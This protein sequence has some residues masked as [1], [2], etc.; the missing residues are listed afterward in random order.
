MFIFLGLHAT[1]YGAAEMRPVKGT[2]VDPLGEPIIGA[3]VRVKGGTVGAQTDLNGGFQ[4]TVSANVTLI[5]SYM[6]YAT[7]EIA[8]TFDAPMKIVL[9]ESSQ[10]LEDVVITAFGTS[11]KKETLTG[12]IQTI[13]PND[14]IA[15]T[16][17]LSNAFAGRLAGVIAFQRSGEPGNSGS[18][19]Y[20]RGISTLSGM[21]SPLIILDGLEVSKEDLNSV[22]PEII[23][24]FS[25]LKDATASAM[26]GTRGANG[27]MIVKTKSG[28]NLERPIIGVRVETNISMPTGIPKF[29]DGATYMELNNEAVT[30][31]NS[32]TGLFS[33]DQILNTRNG[34]D[35]YLYPNVDWYGEVFKDY[36]INQ[37]AN[38]NIRGG[39]KKIVYFMNMTF[40]HETSMLRDRAKEFFSYSN[41]IDLLKYAFQNNI[42]FHL[43]ET[44][45][46]SLHLN[47]QL[48]DKH[49]PNANTENIYN[50]IMIS[51]PVDFPVYYPADE[52]NPWVY[53]G[54]FAGGN[55][56]GAV[57]TVAAMTYGYRD[58]FESTVLANLDFDQ[59]LNF[60]TEGLSFKAKV[61]FKTWNKSEIYRGSSPN[62]Y[63]LRG[64]N[65]DGTYDITPF[66]DPTKPT[67]STAYNTDGDRRMYG[68]AFFSYERTFGENHNVGG[69]LLWNIDQFNYNVGKEDDNNSMLTNSLP[70]RKMGYAMRLTYDYAYRYLLELNAGYNGSENFAA[71]H[72]WGFFPSASVGWNLAQEPFFEPL[73]DIISNLKFR[74][75]YGLVGNDQIN[76]AR[77]IYLGDIERTGSAAYVTG[78][79]TNRYA[80]SGPAY[81]RYENPGITWEVGAKANVGMDMR[82]FDDFNVVVDVFREI[83]SNIFQEM[84]SIPNYFGTAATKVYGNLAKV[85][86]GGVDVSVDY[87][88]K[89]GDDLS[90]EFKSTFTYAHNVVL[91]YDEGVGLRPALSK[92]GQNAKQM[93]GLIS[94]GLYIDY[95]DIAH[96]AESQLGGT[97]APGDVKYVDQPDENGYYDGL[98][99]T[100]DEV[101]I[102]FPEVPEIVY[103]FGPSVQ[104]KSWDFSFFMQGVARTSLMMSGF[105]PFGTQY[106]RNVLQ[107]IADDY[108]SPGNQNINA[109]YPRL[110][111]FD[112]PHNTR[113]SDFWLRDASFLKLKN[114]E[115]GY[116]YHFKTAKGS[117]VR[118]YVSGSNV[119][120]FS[121]FKYWD[122]EMGGGKGLAYPTQR[123]FNVGV[124]MTLK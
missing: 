68:Q 38:F 107:W 71:G 32:S 63:T 112:N 9:E 50:N 8:A 56:Q 65:A 46:I 93:L 86:N 15:P 36:A 82:L 41:N 57:N 5:V 16:S 99:T 55:T 44:S 96:S 70:K 106:N 116:K 60:V 108:W 75:S 72:R 81:R 34:G 111:K 124:Q 13:K 3:T 23:E 91:E 24:G 76:D 39:T 11:Q 28:A 54:I 18:D 62:F 52:Q 85:E 31:Q 12:A 37:K 26:Y 117:Y 61:S 33:A 87:G 27:V 121:S 59:K 105:H 43:S 1:A 25:I 114:I 113:S 88:K 80:Y 97:V 48:N 21:T 115:I 98:I 119:W 2:V 102:G 90:V 22:D 35:P 94:D 120:T 10:E 74:G 47:T 7:Q 84:K 20:I 14:L 73:T 69:L 122:P 92:V 118:L 66:F 49:A 29:V 42:D 40:N 83:R 30:N 4:L 101:P 89:F 78:T 51:N 58:I 64:K 103:G 79:G 95:G 100:N 53:W 45:T 104:W 110:T 67:L 109:N 17:N 6:G 77:F 123:V 19:F